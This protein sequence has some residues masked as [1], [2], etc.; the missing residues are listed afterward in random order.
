MWKALTCIFAILLLFVVAV[1]GVKEQRLSASLAD[2]HDKEVS[3]LEKIKGFEIKIAEL[4]KVWLEFK[5]T[6]RVNQSLASE[7]IALTD[8]LAALQAEYDELKQS[9]EQLRADK[10]DLQERFDV[11]MKKNIKDIMI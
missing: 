3:H 5:E 4:E 8:Q 11:L 1:S 7:K 10:A 6:L 9:E 2:A